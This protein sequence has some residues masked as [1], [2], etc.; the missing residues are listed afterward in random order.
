[1]ASGRKEMVRGVYRRRSGCRSTESVVRAK[2][3]QSTR[4]GR[5]RLRWEQSVKARVANGQSMSLPLGVF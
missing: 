3:A 2:M 1:M 5:G 4:R